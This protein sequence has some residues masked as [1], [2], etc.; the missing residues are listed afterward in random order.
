MTTYLFL[1]DVRY[2]P[3]DGNPWKA[4]R[5]VDE[6]I[7][8]L[9]VAFMSPNPKLVISLDHD[10]GDNVPTGYDF[11]NRFEKAIVMAGNPPDGWGD[12]EFRIHS[13]NPVGRDNMRRAIQSINRLLNNE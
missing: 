9:C 1:D 6:L 4:V 7:T 2:P 13:A 8:T 12:V 3:D 10:L 5:S 11:L